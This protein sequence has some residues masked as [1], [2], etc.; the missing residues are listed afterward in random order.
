MLIN[1]FHQSFYSELLIVSNDLSVITKNP[2][3][4]II[5]HHIQGDQITNEFTNV[6]ECEH[7]ISD[8]IVHNVR[9]WA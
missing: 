7:C 1:M 5:T 6:I 3:R 9:E 4:I 2:S 8:Y